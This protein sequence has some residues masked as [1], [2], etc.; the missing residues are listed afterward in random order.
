[1]ES[2][3]EKQSITACLSANCFTWANV[4]YAPNS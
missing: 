1:L 3:L 2:A 4:I